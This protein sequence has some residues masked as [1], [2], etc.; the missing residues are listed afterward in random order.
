V[1]LD[2]KKVNESLRLL[3]IVTGDSDITVELTN[4]ESQL[5]ELNIHHVYTVLPGAHNMFVWRPALYNFLQ[6]IF[7]H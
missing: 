5:R 2:P 6:K 7:K 3:E 1:L 4:F